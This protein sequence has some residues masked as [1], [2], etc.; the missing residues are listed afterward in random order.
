VGFEPTRE[1][2]PLPVFKTGAL[3]HSATLPCWF[4]SPAPATYNRWSA[5]AGKRAG[6]SVIPHGNGLLP[7]PADEGAR[8]RKT[9]SS[10][11]S[12]VNTSTSGRPL[13]PGKDSKKWSSFP[14]NGQAS[15]V[16]PDIGPK[17]H[18][19]NQLSAALVAKF[20]VSRLYRC[21][22]IALSSCRLGGWLQMADHHEVRIFH[23]RGRN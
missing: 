11:T 15:K 10:Q 20:I 9:I 2:N 6:E 14:Q 21:N 18:C 8:S 23:P 1:R 12:H 13:W 16:L 4:E 22:K 7:E 19:R 17:L 3:N 5:R